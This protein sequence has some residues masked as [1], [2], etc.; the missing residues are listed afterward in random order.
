[1]SV[2]LR[3]TKKTGKNPSGILNQL[4]ADLTIYWIWYT[5]ATS[6]LNWH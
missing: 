6:D 3:R 2:I 4:R 5:P 1:M